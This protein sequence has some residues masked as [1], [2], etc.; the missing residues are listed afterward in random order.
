M[1]EQDDYGL[2]PNTIDSLMEYVDD[3]TNKQKD[4]LVDRNKEY[5]TPDK[6]IDGFYELG[7]IIGENN[8][9]KI[10]QFL[11]GLKMQRIN[12]GIK[13]NNIESKNFLDSI[14]DLI[15]Y[16][17]LLAYTID[18]IIKTIKKTHK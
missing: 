16:L 13:N 11:I 4:V 12:N 10:F 6:V 2:K 3:F 14:L 5:S 18:V 15:N 17:Q 1:Q 9:I 7:N 8:I